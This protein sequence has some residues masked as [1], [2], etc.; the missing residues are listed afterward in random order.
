MSNKCLCLYSQQKTICAPVSLRFYAHVKSSK[1]VAMVGWLWKGHISINIGPNDMNKGLLESQE[2]VLYSTSLTLSIIPTLSG[3]TSQVFQKPQT[4]QQFLSPLYA[5]CKRNVWH[6]LQLV[7]VLVCL[8][9]GIQLVWNAVPSWSSRSTF[10]KTST[11]G[12]CPLP[13]AR[14]KWPNPPWN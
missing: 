11:S 12:P 8:N 6:K 5:E 14:P 4:L 1:T 9:D 3:A 2:A 10:T 7:L 13:S